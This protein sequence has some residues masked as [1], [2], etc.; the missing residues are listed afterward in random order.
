[1]NQQK[2]QSSEKNYKEVNNCPDFLSISLFFFD[3]KGHCCV[4]LDSLTLY[5]GC[6]IDLL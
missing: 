2:K 6:Q 5:K 4:D 3:N 1:M